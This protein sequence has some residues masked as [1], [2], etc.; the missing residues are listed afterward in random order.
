MRDRYRWCENFG[1]N[2]DAPATTWADEHAELARSDIESAV[3]ACIADLDLP[4]KAT[5]ANRRQREA[6]HD[7]RVIVLGKIMTALRDLAARGSSP[8][9]D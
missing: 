4:G 2:I 1:Q 7:A 3:T 9:P 5:P 8:L 6:A